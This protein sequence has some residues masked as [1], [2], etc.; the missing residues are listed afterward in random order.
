MLKG[1]EGESMEG[2]VVKEST[3]TDNETRTYKYDSHVKPRLN[4]I[5][6]W[7]KEGYTD[8]SIA[9]SLGIS[10]TTLIEYKKNYVEMIEVFTRARR[11]RNNLVMNSMFKRANGEVLELNRFK[12]LGKGDIIP[13]TEEQYIPPDVNAADLYLRNNDPE[14]KSARTDPGGLTLIQNNFQLPEAKAEIAR[15]LQEYKQLETLSAVEVQVI[16]E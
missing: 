11:E 5:Y 8:Y 14:Y 1:L 12:V 3:E 9:D 4:E 13:Y 16:E 6:R 15:L 7:V 2:L 10:P